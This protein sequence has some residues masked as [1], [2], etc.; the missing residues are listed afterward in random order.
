MALAWVYLDGSDTETGRAEAFPGREE[1]EAWLAG[2]WA[3]LAASGVA[4]VA[5]LDLDTG[6][7]LYRMS[8]AEG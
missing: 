4:E 8:L 7:R 6:E 1:A 3:E 5:L 2:A